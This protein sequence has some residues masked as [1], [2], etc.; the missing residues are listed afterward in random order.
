[1]SFAWAANGALSDRRAA[2]MA[3]LIEGL[4]MGH[5][6]LLASRRAG[7]TLDAEAQ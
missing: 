5:F 4:Y 2:Q 7:V 6:F 1:M 3:V